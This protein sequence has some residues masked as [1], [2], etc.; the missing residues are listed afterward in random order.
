MAG[1]TRA[2]GYGVD[3]SSSGTVQFIPELWGG[4]L[5]TKFYDTSVLASIAN[6][7]YQGQV[8]DMG[9]NVVIRTRPTIQIDDYEI[10]GGLNYQRPQ[11]PSVSLAIDKA[12]SFAFEV[13]DIEAYQSDV[14][15]MG[16]FTDDA[17]EQ[18]QIVI[19]QQILGDIYADVA[20]ENQGSSAGKISGNVNLGIDGTPVSVTKSNVIDTII[21]VGQVLGEQAVPRQG[22]WIVIPEWMA[23][24]V[25]KSE[26]RDASI[27]GD[28]T[29]IARNGRIGMLDAFTVYVSNNLSVVTDSGSNVVTNVIAGHPASLTW[30][31]QMTRMEH[32]ANPNDFGQLVR[33]LNVYGYK[34]I[35]GQ[36]MVHLRAEK[37]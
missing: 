34:V 33:G 8:R 29:S 1:P 6:T 18:M 14:D 17:T 9:D 10:G 24:M 22:R 7:D 15:M 25:K 2:P 13:N 28:E 3:Y 26:L 20:S 23:A 12:K 31:S 27:A 30:A 19:D 5:T 4:K 32:L 16:E 35:A 37:G 21:D 36:Y 11:S